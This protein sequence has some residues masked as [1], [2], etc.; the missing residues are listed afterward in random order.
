MCTFTPKV[1]GVRPSMSSAQLYISANVVE[2][3]TRPIVAGP[4]DDSMTAF[5]A[6][7][8]SDRAPMDVASF[9]GTLDGKLKT[10]PS[11]APPGAGRPIELSEE[12]MKARKEHFDQFISRQEQQKIK[13]DKHI[14]QVRTYLYLA[15]LLYS[16]FSFFLNSYSPSPS[17]STLQ[18]LDRSLRCYRKPSNS[19]PLIN[20]NYAASLLIWRLHIKRVSFSRGW[21]AT[22]CVASRRRQRR[23]P[24]LILNAHSN[25]RS[26]RQARLFGRVQALS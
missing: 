9:M 12:E 20:Q 21:S 14:E 5:D 16:S 22:F 7:Y 24:R 11:S 3:L 19:H 15:V 8:G 26:A 10:R 6:A 1:K 13:K 4:P 17:P 23:S 25:P 2:R 18:T